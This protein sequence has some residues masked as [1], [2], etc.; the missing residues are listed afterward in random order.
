MHSNSEK[1]V[2]EKSLHIL[3]TGGQL[4]SLTGPPTPEFAEQIGLP[5]HLKLVTKFLSWSVK[6][7]AKRLGVN[8]TFLL[9]R[10]EGN[11][12]SQIAKLIESGKIKPVIDKVFPFDR[13]NEAMSYV[14]GGRA[15]GKV[16]IKV[17]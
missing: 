2:L 14:E 6:K 8:F 15:K 9:M 4:I 1:N 7:K 3:K 13:T 5:W 17:K 10:A 12:L 11:Q 16:V